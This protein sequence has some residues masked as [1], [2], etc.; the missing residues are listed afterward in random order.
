[1][2]CIIIR[3]AKTGRGRQPRGFVKWHLATY[4]Q[5]CPSISHSLTFIRDYS[6]KDRC[7]VEVEHVFECSKNNTMENAF[8]EHN[9]TFA[10]EREGFPSRTGDGERCGSGGEHT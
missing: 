6:S 1:M 3:R 4:V 8:Y 5:A 10:K 7:L 9:M 2:I